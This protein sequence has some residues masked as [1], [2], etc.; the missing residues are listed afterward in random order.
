[1]RAVVQAPGATYPRAALLA[2]KRYRSSTFRGAL[3]VLRH[4]G[5][6]SGDPAGLCPTPKGV[7]AAA[8]GPTLPDGPALVHFWIDE[9]GGKNGRGTAVQAVLE[10]ILE[11]HPHPSTG[12]QIS[13]ATARKR[14]PGYSA[15]SSTMRNALS[16]LR[17]L[18]LVDGSAGF[19]LQLAAAAGMPQALP[20]PDVRGA[21]QEAT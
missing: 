5:Y 6:V 11:A 21:G 13:V 14:L 17:R 19:G 2:G 8:G 18:G 9:L 15:Q 12:E 1:M 7:A 3:K 16:Q 20:S 4:E 10:A